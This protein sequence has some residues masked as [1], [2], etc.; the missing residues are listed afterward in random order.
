MGAPCT[1]SRWTDEN[2]DVVEEV[3]M[4]MTDID[5][6]TATPFAMVDGIRG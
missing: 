1:F 4:V 2:G 6:P 5:E 3:V